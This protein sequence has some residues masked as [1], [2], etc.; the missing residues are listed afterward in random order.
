VLKLTKYLDNISKIYFR[1][2]FVPRVETVIKFEDL[3]GNGIIDEIMDEQYINQLDKH[4]ETQDDN[5]Y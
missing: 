1:K 4:S 3:T 2:H 5:D